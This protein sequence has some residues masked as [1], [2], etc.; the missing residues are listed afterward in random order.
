[1]PDSSRGFPDPYLDPRTGILANKVGARTQSELDVAE[2]ELVPFRAVQLDDHPIQGRFDLDHLR[3]IHRHLFQDVYPFAGEVRTVNIHKLNDPGSGF[4][5]IE[6]FAAGAAYVFGDLAGDKFLRDRTPER[7]VTG[8]AKHFDAINHLHPFREGNGRTQRIFVGQ[9]AAAAGYR[10]DWRAITPEQNVHA[11]REGVRELRTMFTDIVTPIT[12]SNR[13]AHARDAIDA[14]TDID[15]EV[16]AVLKS[17]GLDNPGRGTWRPTRPTQAP[18][19]HPNR[20]RTTERNERD[21]G[22]ER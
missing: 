16:K 22:P 8:V 14:R 11:S 6:R 13:R 10:I 3:A 12:E 17:A 5:P 7:F 18:Q 4:F 19:A 20:E 9:L 2:G 1:M 21:T 15:A